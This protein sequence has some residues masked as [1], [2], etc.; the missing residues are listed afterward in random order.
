MMRIRPDLLAAK[1]Q[2]IRNLEHPELF[3][4]L[5]ENPR[6]VE[7]LWYLQAMSL[8]PGGL[9]AYA[10]TLLHGLAGEFRPVPKP[11]C[12]WW[13]R[14]AYELLGEECLPE[15]D[16]DDQCSAEACRQKA[17]QDL[18]R[19]LSD[20]CLL[21]DRQCK[22]P[23]Y[24]PSLL[25]RL[26]DQMD[27]HRGAVLD[28]IASTETT[29]QA[30]HWL[31]FAFESKTPVPLVGSS[32]FGKTTSIRAW[33][34]S[35]PG[36]ARIVTVPDSNRDRDFLAAHA[37][38]FGIDYN[39]S[40]SSARLREA[41]EYVHRHSGLF[42][43]YDEAQFLIPSNYSKTSAP[44][45]LNWVRC[46]VID[47]GLGCAFFSTPQSY[48]PT[49]ERFAKDTGHTME[50]WIGRMAP[51]VTLPEEL[52]REDL[53]AVASLKFPGIPEPL[54]KVICG[55][56]MRTAGYLKNIELV[57][58]YALFLAKGGQVTLEHVETALETVLPGTGKPAATPE[59]RPCNRT[60]QEGFSG[61]RCER[62][63]VTAD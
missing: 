62:S 59:Q 21:K 17:E 35:R 12:F 38:A 54:R 18:A 41:V 7:L 31:E 6:L 48:L 23:W 10:Q 52:G 34:E 4:Q 36:L 1:L 26:F 51:V 40:T 27:S 19:F 47:R 57:A 5:Q 43:V 15:Q 3:E 9:Q 46:Q 28:Q 11:D 16:E 24:L 60:V 50:Q 22:S 44:K 13:R 61:G 32:R 53:L 25:D 2:A 14:A 39:E 20:L 37:D 58:T 29:R 30:F 56:A 63:L 55:R 45:R 49:L 33:C 8:L 42:V